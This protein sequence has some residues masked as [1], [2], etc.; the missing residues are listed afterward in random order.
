MD[1]EVDVFS[2]PTSTRGFASTNN[3]KDVDLEL[4][5]AARVSL[6]QLLDNV[7]ILEESM[8]ELAAI[9]QVRRSI[10]IDSLRYI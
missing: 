10:G 5:A 1:D 6:S 9:L 3:P 2:A 4:R 7:V 8:K